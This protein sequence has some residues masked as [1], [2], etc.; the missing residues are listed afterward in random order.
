M[1]ERDKRVVFFGLA[2]ILL[3]GLAASYR[4]AKYQDFGFECLTISEPGATTA[5]VRWVEQKD[6]PLDG[7]M[8]GDELWSVAGVEVPTQFHLAYQVAAID[9][10]RGRVPAV[11]V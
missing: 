1:Y 7:P 2:I 10:F 6:E 3:Y 9:P 5:I 8:D 11:Q 4:V